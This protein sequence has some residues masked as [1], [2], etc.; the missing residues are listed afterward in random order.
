MMVISWRDIRGS[1]SAFK[2]FHKGI[3]NSDF[4]HYKLKCNMTFKC[5]DD[6]WNKLSNYGHYK[7]IFLNENEKIIYL[8]SLKK[9]SQTN[10]YGV[11]GQY[12]F[13]SFIH[14][15]WIFVRELGITTEKQIRKTSVCGY[16]I[17]LY[18]N[19]NHH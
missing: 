19:I 7:R 3:S 14:S 5:Q 15:F 1:P 4:I 8:I 10:K 11:L 9:H 17:G 18:V 2:N 12:L 6:T 16:A 13:T